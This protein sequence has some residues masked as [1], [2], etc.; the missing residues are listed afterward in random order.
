MIE[1]VLNTHL[2]RYNGRKFQSRIIIFFRTTFYYCMMEV[3]GIN[4]KSKIRYIV[5]AFKSPISRRL[6]T[7]KIV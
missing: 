5:L 4:K 3:S 1:K 2:L 7:I 6:F